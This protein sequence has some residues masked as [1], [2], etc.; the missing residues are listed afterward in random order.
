MKELI[1]IRNKL[2][3]G[4]E[5]NDLLY[6]KMQIN[7]IDT[8]IYNANL[9]NI[10]IDTFNSLIDRLEHASNIKYPNRLWNAEFKE[11][12]KALWYNKQDQLLKYVLKLE[13]ELNL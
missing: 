10:D 3:I 2:L 4:V 11:S 12:A 5:N 7:K 6:I 9:L 1:E 8:L 13:K